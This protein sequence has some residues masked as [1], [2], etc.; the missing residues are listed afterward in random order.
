MWT[1]SK[2][3]IVTTVCLFGVKSAIELKIFKVNGLAGKV[4]IIR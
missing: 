1:P 4:R 2:V 3:P